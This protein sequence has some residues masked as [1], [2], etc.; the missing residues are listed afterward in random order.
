MSFTYDSTVSTDLAKVRLNIQDTVSTSAAFTDEE[1]NAILGQVG[2]DVNRASGRLLM[3]LA[4]NKAKLAIRRS[5]GDYSEDLTALAK[6]LR[7][8][9]KAFLEL[10]AGEPAEATQETQLTDFNTREFLDGEA[11]RGN[12]D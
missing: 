2:N 7:E 5:A 4:T 12:L 1:I 6:E 9:A 10:A 11:I 3:I 8:Q